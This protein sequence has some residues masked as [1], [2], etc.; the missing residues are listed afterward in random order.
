MCVVQVMLVPEHLPAYFV[1]MH[2]QFYYMCAPRTS[3]G[4]R[5]L[6]VLSRCCRGCVITHSFA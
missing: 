2:A 1:F 6:L 4:N 3:A 5:S